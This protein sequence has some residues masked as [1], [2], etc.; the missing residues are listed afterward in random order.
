MNENKSELFES[1]QSTQDVDI[2]QLHQLLD[3]AV[4]QLTK[5]TDQDVPQVFRNGLLDRFLMGISPLFR[6][7]EYTSVYEY[8]L[9][10]KQGIATLASI[11]N[12]ITQSYSIEGNING[13]PVYVSPLDVQWY[14][15]GVMFLQGEEKFA[16]LAG[17]YQDGRVKFAVCARDVKKGRNLEPSDFLFIDAEVA[18]KQLT[19]TSQLEQAQL[20]QAVIELTQLLKKQE[21]Q[22]S[23][24]Q[25][26]LK[27]YPWSFGAQYGSVHSHQEFNDENIPDFSGVRI[28]DGARDIIEIKNPFL[29][30]F[31]ADGEFTSDFYHAW[32]QVERYLDFARREP[33]YLRR[34]KG[35][36]FENPHCYLIAGYCLS[37]KQIDKLHVK[38]RMNPA[39]TILTYDDLLTLIDGTVKFVEKLSSSSYSPSKSS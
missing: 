30:L 32:N 13:C 18:A 36:R 39:I 24:Y 34:Q 7:E 27:K 29:K 17:L 6:T 3:F 4:S 35:L 28:R 14:E 33:D 15:D 38:E 12:A 5:I 11:R 1:L 9:R 22:E 26:F 37:E 16:G 23:K 2:E 31:R 21:E 8:L 20:Q 25:Y 19:A 10:H